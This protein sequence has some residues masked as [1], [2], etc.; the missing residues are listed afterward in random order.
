MTVEEQKNQFQYIN[1]RDDDEDEPAE[2]SEEEDDEDE[3]DEEE[4]VDPL[5]VEREKCAKRGDAKKWADEL[6]ECTKRVESKEN[7]T[8]TCTFELYHFLHHRDECIAG[9]F[10]SIIKANWTK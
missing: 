10:K 2:E 8:E 7:T 3:D 4:M 9:R 1:K 6:A 5:V